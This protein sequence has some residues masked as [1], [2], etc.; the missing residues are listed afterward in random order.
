[1]VGGKEASDAQYVEH[2]R[3]DSDQDPDHRADAGR[4]TD[5]GTDGNTT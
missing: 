1:M 5:Q 2:D 3:D 4:D